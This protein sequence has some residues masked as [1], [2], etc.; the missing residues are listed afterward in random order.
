MTDSKRWCRLG[1]L[2]LTLGFVVDGSVAAQ[3]SPDSVEITGRIVDSETGDGLLGAVLAL[4]GVRTRFVTDE[5]GEVTFRAAQGDYILVVQ[6]GG[7]E[8]LQGDFEVMRT[9]GFVLGLEPEELEDPDAQGRVIGRI[10]DGRSGAP[11]EGA[12]VSLLGRGDALTNQ[13]GRFEFEEVLPGLAEVRVEMLGYAD[14]VD[15]LTIHAGR[16]IALNVRMAVDPVALEPLEVEVRSRFLELRGVYQRMEQGVSSH[17]L[18]RQE[19]E[20]RGTNRFSDHLDGISGLRINQQGVRRVLTGRGNCP[21]AVFVDGIRWQ[22][23]IEGTVDIDQIPSDWIEVAEIFNGG[24]GAPAEYS[25][26][27]DGCGVMLIWTRQGANER[28]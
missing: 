20:D 3:E 12:L 16:T 13:N 7:Y 23:D 15:P 21:I 25:R 14:R 8:T 19:I 5:D 18:T 26:D 10:L 28:G 24:V 22:T 2:C 11:I 27:T 9:G 1:I 6:R 4:S 17:L